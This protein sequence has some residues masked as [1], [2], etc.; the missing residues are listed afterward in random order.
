MGTNPFFSRYQASEQNLIEDLVVESIKIHG[1]DMI[2]LLRET[3]NVDELFGEDVK[4][5]FTDSREIEMY[6]DSVDGFDGDGDFV[7]KFGLEIRDSM[8]VVVS[9]KR[10]KEVF[11]GTGITGASIPREGD[12][13]YFPLSKGIFEITFVE[14]ENPFYQLGKNH[15]FK[16][17]CQLFKYSGETLDTGFTDIDEEVEEYKEFAI[18]LIMESGGTG[19]FIDGETV[20]QGTATAKV[21]SFNSTTRKLRITDLSGTI[22]NGLNIVG[23]SSGASWT[24]NGG[25]QTTTTVNTSPVNNDAM[26]IDL[27]MDDLVDFTITNPFGEDGD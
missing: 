14:H 19:T 21:V 12:L 22:T 7:A 24:Y 8:S 5:K 23:S 6:I 20:T 1:H 27:E 13:I 26:D 17:S 2:Y 3:V 4:N 9:K 10:W 15:T 11:T 16:L 18:D 25:G